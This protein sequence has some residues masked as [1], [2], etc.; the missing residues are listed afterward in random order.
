MRKTKRKAF[1]NETNKKRKIRKEEKTKK[2][3][4]VSQVLLHRSYTDK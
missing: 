1:T 4:R 2:A 3:R